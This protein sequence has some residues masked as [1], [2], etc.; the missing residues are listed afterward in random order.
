MMPISTFGF[1]G[2]AIV[3]GKECRCDSSQWA[4]DLQ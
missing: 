2:E 4:E 1:G 3:D